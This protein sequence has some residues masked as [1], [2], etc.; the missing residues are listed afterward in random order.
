[1]ATLIAGSGADPAQRY[2][3]QWQHDMTPNWMQF[4]AQAGNVTA[5]QMIA[6]LRVDQRQRWQ[7]G[8][9]ARIEDY[10]QTQPDLKASTDAIL[11]LIYNEIV[12]REEVG[13]LPELDEYQGRFPELAG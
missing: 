6:V 11:D 12:L 5:E 9:P 2:L 10:L 8:N 13:Q 1:T 7:R 3:E 4:L